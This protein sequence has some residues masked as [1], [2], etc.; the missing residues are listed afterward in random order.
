[1]SVLTDILNLFGLLGAGPAATKVHDLNV[2]V[3][4]PL[5]VDSLTFGPVRYHLPV[6]DSSIGGFR[7]FTLTSLSTP[8][9]IFGALQANNLLRP[10]PADTT[11][12]QV[13][14]ALRV[15]Y[16]ARP[17][18]P[19]AIAGTAKLP[20]VLLNHG[21]HSSWEPI[22]AGGVITGVTVSP[23]LNGYGYLQEALAQHGIVS[24][25]VDHNFGC[26]TNSF[27]ETRA[28]TVIAALNV[29][30]TQAASATSRYLGRLDFTKVGLMGHSRGGD[31]V[32]RAVKKIQADPALNSRYKILAVCSLAP[33]DFTGGDDPVNRKFLDVNDVNFYL[34]VYGALDGDV[35]GDNATSPTGTGFRHY[36]R[37]R[38]QKAMV[39]LDNC[40]HNPFN[41]VWF[42]DGNDST[43]PRIASQA[44][45]QSLAI[46]YIG[47]LFRWQLKGEPLGARF[48]G[49]RPNRVGQHASVQW[50]YG[51]S[52]KR[53]DDFENPAANMLGGSRTVLNP[54]APTSIDDFASITV[55]ATSLQTH[56]AHQTQVLH[57]DLTQA[58]PGSTRVLTT[59]IPAADQDWSALDTL[60]VSLSGWFD[61]TSTATI[62]AANLPRLTI[63]L[64]DATG[65]TASTGFAVYGASLPSRPIFKTLPG[66]GNITLMRLETIPI[67]LAAFAGVDLT[68]ITQVALDIEANNDTH[69]FVDNIHAVKQL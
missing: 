66:P 40:C 69:V 65:A 38:P 16:P 41:T 43:D 67:A 47:D 46:D 13:R 54:G 2:W 58:A 57:V 31:T 42:A 49:G 48:D 29:M 50:M 4:L 12:F 61:P 24:V 28:D 5:T 15:T 1:M 7:S 62:A 11:K 9:D 55:G 53:I 32:V 33:T 8:L 39:F 25:S 23:S 35:N 34:V 14:L 63:T 56:T 20:V 6:G 52:L 37:A 36:D 10:D 22:V 59:D 44:D 3:P 27:I 26:F 30:A 45:H 19:N 51:Q 21:N 68:K 18:H 60:V 17:G 64:V